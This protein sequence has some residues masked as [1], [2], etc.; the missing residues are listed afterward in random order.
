M[1]S[2]TLKLFL[3]QNS[4]FNTQ[5][6]SILSQIAAACCSISKSVR[7]GAFHNSLGNSDTVNV[8][9]ETQ[10]TLDL[11]ANEVFIEFCSS[12]PFIAG[13]VSEE[14]EEVIWLKKNPKMGD[15]LVYFDPLDGS[16]NID[17]DLSVGTIFSMIKI[18]DQNAPKTVFRRGNEQCCSGY[19][20]YG[21]STMLVLAS[22]ESANGFTLSM[23]DEQFYLT[24]PS[25]TIPS[26]T[27]EYA[28]NASRSRH[29][30][31]PMARYIREL[32]EGE[33][34]CRGRNFNMRWT[35]SMVA[36][37]HRILMRGGVFFYPVDE[38]NAS[39]GGKLRLMYEANPMALII[40]AAGG[41]ATT[42]TKR[43]LEIA[44]DNHHQRV[45]V[46]LGS[47]DEIDLIRSYY[48]KTT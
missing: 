10:K 29:W 42:G 1:Q 6:V 2:Q 40:E 4:S 39:M 46:M 34:G 22:P 45:S 41:A 30:P 15:Y 14:V 25:L 38:N 47:Q 33:T 9:G 32:N 5:E 43:I 18:T 16:S 44:P 3:D 28:I 48:Q 37:V 19:A 24:H 20:I 13:L 36:E 27:S 26:Q 12:N 35:A 21:P 23:K 7:D 11:L 17:V 31:K 8:Q